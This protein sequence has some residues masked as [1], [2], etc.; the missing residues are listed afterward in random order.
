MFYSVVNAVGQ[1]R[2]DDFHRQAERDA[3]A[4][5]ARQARR[6]RRRQGGTPAVS[7]TGAAGA[8]RRRLRLVMPH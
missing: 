3:L 2:L 4:R 7:R 1:A 8:L 6:A 5:A